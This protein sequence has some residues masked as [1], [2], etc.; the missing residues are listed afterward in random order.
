M[1]GYQKRVVSEKAK[2]DVKL[3]LLGN[4]IESSGFDQ[5]NKSEAKLLVKQHK[6]M[7]KY[8]YVLGKRIDTFGEQS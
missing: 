1:I 5:V 3:M 4:F 8:A 6:H 7:T 2:L